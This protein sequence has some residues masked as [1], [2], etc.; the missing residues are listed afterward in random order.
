MRPALETVAV[1]APALDG[2][3]NT[4]TYYCAILTN[5]GGFTYGTII[6][7]LATDNSYYLNAYIYLQLRTLLFSSRKF[8]LNFP[9]LLD[10]N[11]RIFF[12]ILISLVHV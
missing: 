11:I 4:R 7:K 12:I 10:I 3:K 9:S 6:L 5:R 2:T 8:L 1:V